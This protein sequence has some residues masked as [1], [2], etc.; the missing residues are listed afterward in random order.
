MNTDMGSKSINCKQYVAWPPAKGLLDKAI[1]LEIQSH[2]AILL[3]WLNFVSQR[4]S[5]MFT[6]SH[7][8]GDV[9]YCDFIVYLTLGH[10]LVNKSHSFFGMKLLIHG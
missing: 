8:K 2:G 3:L 1:L 7:Q 4:S 9:C 5:Q 6:L 10:E